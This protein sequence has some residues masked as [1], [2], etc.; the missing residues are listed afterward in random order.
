M[1][2]RI[3]CINHPSKGFDDGSIIALVLAGLMHSPMELIALGA[4]PLTAS[5]IS[6]YQTVIR[7]AL[8]GESLPDS[9]LVGVGVVVVCPSVWC[10]P[11]GC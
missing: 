11:A 5:P 8:D 1:L 2:Q 3:G 9:C 10:F 7:Q 6:G 4:G